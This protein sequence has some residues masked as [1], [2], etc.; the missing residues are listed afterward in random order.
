[1]ATLATGAILSAIREVIEDGAGSIRTITADIYEA[2]GFDGRESLGV[3]VEALSAPRAQV[4]I[5]SVEP[6]P[7][8]PPITGSFVLRLLTIE[9]KLARPAGTAD[10]LSPAAFQ[11]LQELAAADH[12]VLAQALT[13]P[14]NLTTGGSPAVA[15]GLVSGCLQTTHSAAIG[16][17]EFD[18]PDN[19]RLVTIHTFQGVAKV[20]LATS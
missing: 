18:G 8:S 11:A 7:A 4:R 3:S 2:G 13:W 17:V 10:I 14:G 16:T 15:T 1:M 9:V 12:D 19:G 6:H 20:T 5:A